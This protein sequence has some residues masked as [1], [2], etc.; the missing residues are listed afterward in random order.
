MKAYICIQSVC[1]GN[2][3]NLKIIVVISLKMLCLYHLTR[4]VYILLF[5]ILKQ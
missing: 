3:A 2:F 5:A 1:S 4:T